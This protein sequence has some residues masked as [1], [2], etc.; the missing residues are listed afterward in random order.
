MSVGYM[1]SDAS[2]DGFTAQADAQINIGNN[3]LKA[4]ANDQLTAHKAFKQEK[5]QWEKEHPGELWDRTGTNDLPPL[6]SKCSR[7][8][9]IQNIAEYLN[10]D[11]KPSPS[12][13]HNTIL[14]YCFIPLVICITTAGIAAMV[15]RKRSRE[16]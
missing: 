10:I 4:L 12:F 14:L 8:D 6:I 7:V 11:M 15:Y 16:N 3:E 1:S 9:N 5:E 2:C 13:S